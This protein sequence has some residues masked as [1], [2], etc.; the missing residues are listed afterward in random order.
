MLLQK[1]EGLIPKVDT[2]A[3][4]ERLHL[5]RGNRSDA[6]KFRDRQLLDEARPHLRRDDELPVGLMMVGGQLSQELIVRDAR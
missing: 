4:A 5:V 2:G 3:D 6:M 1:G